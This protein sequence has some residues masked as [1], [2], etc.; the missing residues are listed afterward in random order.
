[1]PCMVGNRGSIQPSTILLS[2]NHVSFRLDSSVNWKLRRENS[3]MCTFRSRSAFWIH[4][5]CASRSLDSS[6]RMAWVTPSMESTIG[7]AK[8]YVG[9]ALY[10][11]LPSRDH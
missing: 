5:N 4:S 9:Y 2:T 10:L 8:S 11:P 7:Q 3:T 6:V 1:M